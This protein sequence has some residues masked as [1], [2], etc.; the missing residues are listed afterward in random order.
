MILI[1]YGRGDH[2]GNFEIFAQSLARELGP[3]VG[4]DNIIQR[5][6]ERKAASFELLASPPLKLGQTISQLHIFSHSIGGGL[7][8]GYGDVSLGQMRQRLID[9]AERSFK[10]LSYETVV[11]A[12]EGAV[13]TDDFLRAPYSTMRSK[14]RALFSAHAQIKIWGCNSG[15][16]G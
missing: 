15:I 16:K 4:R 7:F 14:L 6:I 8:L 10:R 1:I 11:A 12:E 5:R 2:L 9:R 3:E 13:L